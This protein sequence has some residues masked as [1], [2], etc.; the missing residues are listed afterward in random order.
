M[1]SERNIVGICRNLRRRRS[2]TA[3]SIY[4]IMRYLRRILYDPYTILERE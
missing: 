4:D 3:V 2:L 1:Y